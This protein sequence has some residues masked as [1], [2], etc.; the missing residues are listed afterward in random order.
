MRQHI[1]ESFF[2]ASLTGRYTNSPE[3]RFEADL[4]L[5][6][7][8]SDEK[9]LVAKLREISATTLSSDYW[10]ITLPTQLAT[11]AAR[12]PSLFAYQAALINLDACA[13]YSQVKIAA[14][15]DPA[16]QGPKAALEQHHLF[17]GGT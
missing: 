3:T 4:S 12:S 6:R 5:I 10:S 14:M 17:R 13:L 1:A 9:T 16:V 11:S 8:L 7:H 2:M 15:V